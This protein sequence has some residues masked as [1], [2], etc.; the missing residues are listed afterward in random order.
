ML[1]ERKGGELAPA[2]VEPDVIDIVLVDSR[3]EV[4]DMTLRY[5]AR[6]QSCMAL[7]REGIRVQDEQRI[8]G[9]N[10]PERVFEGQ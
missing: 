1:G 10:S 5:A 2:V 4:R 8:L 9:V 3:Q 7:G 6:I